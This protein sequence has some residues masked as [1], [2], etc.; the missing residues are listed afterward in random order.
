MPSIGKVVALIS[1]AGSSGPEIC[2]FEH[3]RAGIQLPAGTLDPDEDPI[4][5]AL[6][7]GFEET[8]LDEV[9][10]T[11]ELAVLPASDPGTAIINR[12][13]TF[14][15]RPIPPGYQAH[16]LEQGPTTSRV[17][18]NTTSER[19][20]DVIDNDALSIDATRHIVHMSL[21]GST[22]DEWWVMTPDGDGVCWR[23]FWLPLHD[24]N[25]VVSTQRPWLEA[26]GAELMRAPH[27]AVERRAVEDPSVTSDLNL[28]FFFA[29][30]LPGNRVQVSWIEPEHMPDEPVQRSEVVAFTEDQRIVTVTGDHSH[31][32]ELPGGHREEGESLEDTLRRELWEEACA[33]LIEFE[34]I[35]Y[36]RFRHL[37]AGEV[38]RT[39][40]DA[41]YWGRV[42]CADFEPRFETRARCLL[43]IAEARALPLWSHPLC[44]RQLDR[45]I[46]AERRAAEE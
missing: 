15:G 3:P 5:G 42:R 23:C 45:A 16:F 12:L 2:V 31:V 39:S 44:A 35:G 36:Q 21:R 22:P 38:E 14:A 26:V 24:A 28:E 8:G 40:L 7:E 10:V 6:R 18:V 33:E 37:R 27:G 4:A 20:E 46:S 30:P 34:L 1:R 9:E 13:V 25:R 19:L 32:I 17:Q 11:G 29:P 41:M 43:T